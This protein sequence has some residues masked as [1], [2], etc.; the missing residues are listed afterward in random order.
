MLLVRGGRGRHRPR[1]RSPRRHTGIDAAHPFRRRARAGPPPRACITALRTRTR[2]LE[3]RG[4]AAEI[5]PPAALDGSAGLTAAGIHGGLHVKA[6]FGLDPGAYVAGLARAARA[7]GRRHPG[8]KRRSPAFSHDNAGHRPRPPRAAPSAHRRL[9]VAT[10]GYS[11]EDLPAWLAGRPLP[12]QSSVIVTRPLT[13]AEQRGA[14]LDV[15]SHG[16]RQPR[17]SALFPADARWALPVRHA[18]RHPR[19]A[20]APRPAS[21]RK[22][23]ARFRRD[24][25]GL[26]RCRDRRMSGRALSTCRA[27]LTPLSARSP[28]SATPGPRWPITATAWRWPAIPGAGGRSHPRTERPTAPFPTVMQA[29]LGRFPLGPLP[30]ALLVCRHHASPA[31]ADRSRR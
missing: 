27:R 8:A 9:L 14:G 7:A 12:V 29:P 10:N 21:P 13:A 4:V 11:S 17:A 5:L 16:L 24:V 20:R 6:G 31:V 23:R 18:R 25:S 1:G 30:P 19:D 26:G 22:I 3:A 28:G 15:R 2:W